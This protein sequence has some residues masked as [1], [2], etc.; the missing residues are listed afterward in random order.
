MEGGAFSIKLCMVSR[1]DNPK[2]TFVNSEDIGANFHNAEHFLAFPQLKFS[3]DKV[4]T[5]Y[6]TEEGRWSDIIIII[7]I[8]KY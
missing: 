6:C 2:K 8:F 4:A 7:I 5:K 1:K 3:E